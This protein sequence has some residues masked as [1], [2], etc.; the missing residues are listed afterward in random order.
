MMLY[1]RL[2]VLVL[3]V[4]SLLP[5][6]AEAATIF[7]FYE[8]SFTTAAR[9]GL[10]FESFE[11]AFSAAP[12]VSFSGFT[13][14]ESGGTTNSVVSMDSVGAAA[15]SISNAITDG[16]RVASFSDNGTSVLTFQFESPISAF[17]VFFTASALTS[18][19]ITVGGASVLLTDTPARTPQFVGVRDDAGT[20]QTITFNVSGLSVVGFDAVRFAAPPVGRPRA[21]IHAP[22]RHRPNRRGRAALSSATL[23]QVATSGTGTVRG[24]GPFVLQH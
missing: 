8:A 13:M 10:S 16:S 24:A 1:L 12:S 11:T 18:T 22:P 9:S 5:R 6:A 2:G 4:L 19:S 23:P 21:D 15:L 14:T 7:D 3:V 20:F 17:G